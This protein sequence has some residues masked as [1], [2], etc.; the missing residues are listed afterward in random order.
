MPPPFWAQLTEAQTRDG[1]N[2]NRQHRGRSPEPGARENCGAEPSGSVSINDLRQREAGSGQRPPE[3][4]P[5][6]LRLPWGDPAPPS[7]GAPAGRRTCPWW[8]QGSVPLAHPADA[9]PSG[10]PQERASHPFPKGVTV[11]GGLRK[12]TSGRT[13]PWGWPKEGQ[14]SHQKNGQNRPQ[15]CRRLN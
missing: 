14:F 5:P 6:H 9:V 15:P 11:S 10:P 3:R 2:V 4:H 12:K 13:E 7:A 1:G 8:G